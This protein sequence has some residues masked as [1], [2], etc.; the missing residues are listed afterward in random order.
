MI[1]FKRKG[2]EPFLSIIFLLS[3]FWIIT[4]YGEENIT[5]SF[6]LEDNILDVPVLEVQGVGHYKTK[7]ALVEN[8]RFKLAV[9]EQSDWAMTENV[10]QTATSTMILPIVSVLQGGVIISRYEL[11]LLLEDAEELLFS[12][13]YVNELPLDTNSSREKICNDYGC[14]EL[15]SKLAK[16]EDGEISSSGISLKKVLWE[17]DELDNIKAQNE[18]PNFSS[19][20]RV[21]YRAS[22]SVAVVYGDW[23]MNQSPN[24]DLDQPVFHSTVPGT[25]FFI[26]DSL[27]LTTAS[28]LRSMKDG[29]PYIRL[30]GP[31]PYDADSCESYGEQLS[32]NGADYN[33]VSGAGPVI[34]MFDGRWALAE[35]VWTDD[36]RGL[37]AIRLVSVTED[38]R[39]P[40]VSWKPWE[41]AIDNQHWLSLRASVVNEIGE[42]ATL[43]HPDLARS[44]GG[45]FVSPSNG[46]NCLVNASKTANQNEPKNEDLE[47][48]YLN[49][50]SDPGSNGA[51]I[52]DENGI[53]MA[54]VESQ[55]SD[56]DGELCPSHKATTTK[57]S[58]G[59]LPRYF[60]DSS[61]LTVGAPI[62]TELIELLK[63]IDPSINSTPSPRGEGL[64]NRPSVS[65]ENFQRFEVPVMSDA[66]TESG[67]P[68]SQFKSPAIDIAKQ[69]T[70]AFIRETGC[71]DCDENR[72]NSNFDVPCI[73]TGFAVSE[74]L[75]VT[76]DHCVPALE[77]GAKTTF[78]TFYGQDVEAE[79]VGKSSLDG[80]ERMN[81]RYEEIFGKQKSDGVALTGYER[82]DVALLRTT[83]AMQ[84]ITPLKFGDSS[85]L[86]PWEP[87]I[88]VGHPSTMA[89][90][91]PW[92]TGVGSFLGADYF[93]RTSQAYN[94]PAQ[95]GASGSAVVNLKG[96]LVGQIANGGVAAVAEKSAVLP[97]KY[98]LFAVELEVDLLETSPAPYSRYPGIPISSQVSN[99]APSNYI[100]ELIEKWAPG[101]LSQ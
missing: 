16:Q 92:V 2:R 45:W 99:G 30:P 57:N 64:P 3:I 87:L 100:K 80:E 49:H 58:L 69:A 1:F 50:Y 40:F 18:L 11:Q 59:P 31:P 15:Q 62:T 23:C 86:Q 72:L 41:G 4:T 8:S 28:V 35:V 66:F 75:I 65:L 56:S 32:D 24:A 84:F 91:G 68:V 33:L 42:T 6:S 39:L 63:K 9:I 36:I 61:T 55:R 14:F 38:R 20:E 83:Q 48:L 81:L 95:R 21:G 73:C 67:F 74:Y 54:I 89:R 98:N 90:T 27:V 43:H 25:G 7:L 88:T 78:R 77:I 29:D 46:M 37:G 26:S 51:P 70:V 96:E 53:V 34:Q 12:L 94:L 60:A 52:I 85:A 97:G 22:P 47:K 79:L 19:I 101:E 44:E 13:S 10:F 93:T 82:G 71:P 17:R 76:N 5:A